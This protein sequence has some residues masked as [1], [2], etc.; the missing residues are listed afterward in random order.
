DGRAI[1]ALAHDDFDGKTWQRWSRHRTP[2]NRW[3]PG[4]DGL[5][6]HFALVQ[7]WLARELMKS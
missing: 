3:R 1:G 6:T 4:I 5:S 2:A 7:E